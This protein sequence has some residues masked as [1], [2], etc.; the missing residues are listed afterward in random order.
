[1]E[2]FP[3]VNRNAQGSGLCVSDVLQVFPSGKALDE[4]Q[5]VLDEIRHM[6]GEVPKSHVEGFWSQVLRTSLKKVTAGCTLQYDIVCLSHIWIIL[7]WH[8]VCKGP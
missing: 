5:Q 8:K 4:M 3:E 6:A 2:T 1:M 7:C